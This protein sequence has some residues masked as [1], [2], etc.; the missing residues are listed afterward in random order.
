[1]TSAKR[2]RWVDY[3]LAEGAHARIAAALPTAHGT[4]RR[5]SGA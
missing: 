2:G 3:T 1:M 5:R 4:P